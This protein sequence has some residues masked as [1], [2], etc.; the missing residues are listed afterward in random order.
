MKQLALL[1]LAALALKGYAE[2]AKSTSALN[3]TRTEISQKKTTLARLEALSV[4]M[5]RNQFPQA[6]ELAERLVEQFEGDPDFDF[7]Y[8][9]AAI[10]TQHFDEALFAFERLVIS[11]P[12]QPRY[13][14]ELARTHFY[15]RNLI[16]AE[17]EFHK[18]LKQKPPEGVVKNVEKFLEQI[19]DLQR[20][21]QPRFM[22]ALDMAGGF[23]SNINSATDE[24][25]LLAE[26]SGGFTD[27]NIPEDSREISSAYYNTLLN[28]GYV[29]P[30]SKTTS[31]DLRVIYSKRANSETEI[32]DF[33]TAMAELGYSFYTGPIQWRG[34][35]RYQY[36]QLN[37]EEFLNTTSFQAQSYWRLRSGF[38]YGFSMN[39]GDTVYVENDNGDL[40]Q[41]QYIF[42]FISAPKKTSWMISL[43]FGDDEPGDKVNNN[44]N[45][46]SYQGFNYRSTT[47]W[48][49][50]GSRYWLL[51]V[52]SSEYDDL[53]PSFPNKIR[54]D[55]TINYGYGWRYA[56]TSSFSIRNDYGLT[57]SDSELEI[58]TYKRAKVEFG[59]TYSF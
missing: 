21:V 48:G 4:L 52:T 45:G 18:V 27:L 19:A 43:L 37:G 53:N 10:E 35:G 50:R 58:Y 44:H 51:G 26:D 29:S 12:D 20:T 3:N 55:Q 14:L 22:F 28:L 15:L 49:A 25:L 9:M 8:G 31:Y 23:D 5:K 41:Q 24:E 11:F 34:A 30:L 13:R 16:R 6:F 2:E 33:D 17:I 39:Y 1:L 54:K 42:S 46:K 38:T 57:Y 32:Y 56:F 7:K 47:L 40:T 59:L 36:V